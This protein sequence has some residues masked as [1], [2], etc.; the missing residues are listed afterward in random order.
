MNIILHIYVQSTF[1]ISEK[2]FKK[3]K[4]KFKKRKWTFFSPHQLYKTRLYGN[5]IAFLRPPEEESRFFFFLNYLLARLNNKFA[6][7]RLIFFII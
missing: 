3:K 7:H 1:W 5:Y 4:S 6:G 2:Y